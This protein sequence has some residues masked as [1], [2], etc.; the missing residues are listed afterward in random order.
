[1]N[2]TALRVIADS[3]DSAIEGGLE[4]L[5]LKRDDV[6]VVINRRGMSLL[7]LV[8]MPAVVSIVYAN[9]DVGSALKLDHDLIQLDISPE[10]VFLVHG[11]PLDP[12]A[13]TVTILNYLEEKNIYGTDEGR[14]EEF[15][16]SDVDEKILI[17]ELEAAEAGE[18]K[19]GY[20]ISEDSMRFLAVKFD[21]AEIAEDDFRSALEKAGVEK[22]VNEQV[23]QEV[24]SEGG[25]NVFYLIA[26]GA[27]AVDDVVQQPF[28]NV[29]FDQLKPEHCQNPDDPALPVVRIASIKQNQ[30]I[31]RR[32]NKTPGRPGYR[33]DGS[34]ID[35]QEIEWER[36]HE[37]NHTFSVSGE[38]EIYASMSGQAIYHDDGRFDVSPVLIVDGDVGDEPVEFEGK[39]IVTGNA[40]AESI[41]TAT[42]DVIV[43]GSADG[44]VIGSG[45]EV[46]IY[47][48]KKLQPAVEAVEEE[49]EGP[50]GPEY[51]GHEEVNE[52]VLELKER[53]EEISEDDYG[54]VMEEIERQTLN[55]VNNSSMPDR[56]RRNKEAFEELRSDHEQLQDISRKIKVI[57]PEIERLNE[58]KGSG[59][60][61]NKAQDSLLNEHTVRMSKLMM[62]KEEKKHKLLNISKDERLSV[63]GNREY[64]VAEEE[65]SAFLKAIEKYAHEDSPG[66]ISAFEKIDQT[67][68]TN[69]GLT[70]EDTRKVQQKLVEVRGKIEDLSPRVEKLRAKK[71]D[72]ENLTDEERA[73]L[74]EDMA[75]LMELMIQ[76]EEDKMKLLGKGQL[77]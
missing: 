27:E 53:I 71:E 33:V 22:G 44:A 50:V 11:G 55:I 48:G 76:E 74:D 13:T 47:N 60:E 69:S 57:V 40:P 41:I 6:E 36:I 19:L 38:A 56:L 34:V 26:E 43:L 23:V 5:A 17:C 35:F 70:I 24:C 66:S 67:V 52:E 12:V 65:V 72:G 54:I 73:V 8:F 32:G 59:E 31:A 49:P 9:K 18:S 62:L 77:G 3:V 10:G 21:A 63:D 28:F 58:L 16:K 15:L 14:I 29:I 45:G 46:I 25:E 2:K 7:G 20:I 30:L 68:N 1:M 61:L 39:I 37:G 75:V 51:I 64:E 42:D 4:Q